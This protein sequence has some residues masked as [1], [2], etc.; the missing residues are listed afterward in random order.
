M[1]NA[2]QFA[3][4]C[5]GVITNLLCIAY[6]FGAFKNSCREEKRKTLRDKKVSTKKASASKE[7]GNEK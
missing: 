6:F 2:K 7:N 1:S 4:G 3:H 5:F